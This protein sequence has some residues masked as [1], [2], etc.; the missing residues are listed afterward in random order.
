MHRTMY[1]NRRPTGAELGVVASDYDQA[2]F[3]GVRWGS[4]CNESTLE[5]LPSAHKGP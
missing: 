3:A 5:K 1:L 4:G 2:G